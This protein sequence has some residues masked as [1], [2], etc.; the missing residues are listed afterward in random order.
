M[1]IKAYMCGTDWSCDLPLGAQD[2]K[3]YTNLKKFKKDRE[4]GIIEIE[5]VKKR[6]V[7]KGTL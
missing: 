7:K 2:I 6:I 4:C 3:I 5:I 1:K